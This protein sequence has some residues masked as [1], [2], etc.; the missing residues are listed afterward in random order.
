M[1]VIK[2]PYLFV[3]GF[4]NDQKGGRWKARK[5]HFEKVIGEKRLRA[6]GNPSEGFVPGGKKK[7]TR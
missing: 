7:A 2:E 3:F 1:N 5:E 6:I 4:D